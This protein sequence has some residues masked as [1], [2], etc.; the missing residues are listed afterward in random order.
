M[1]IA[2]TK[3]KKIKSR[4]NSENTRYYSLKKILTSHLL[5]KNVNNKIQK[6]I[7]LPVFF[8]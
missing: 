6:T 4:L 5:P 2:I 8:V 7:I 1:K 3:K